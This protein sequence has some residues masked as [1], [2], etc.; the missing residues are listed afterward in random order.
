MRHQVSKFKVKGDKDR[1]T[2]RHKDRWMGGWMDVEREEERDRMW[3]IDRKK[4]II[5]HNIIY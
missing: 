5:R 2:D 4:Y 3:N 1:Q